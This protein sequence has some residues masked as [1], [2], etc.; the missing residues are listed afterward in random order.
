VLIY[1]LEGLAPYA[2]PTSALLTHLSGGALRLVL[3]V[4]TA[5]E[6]LAG[7]Y[8]D[9][10]AVKVAQVTAFLNGL[11]NTEWVDVSMPIADRAA[12]LRSHGLRMPDAMVMGTA[13]V[14]GADVLLTND[15]CLRRRL[16]G[17]PRV[18]LLDEYCRQA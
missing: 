2:D 5:A 4:L 16:P 10:S 6:V 15:P 9:R 3:S 7:P 17:A 14:R 12:W 13:L 8:R 1:H 18:L 11:P